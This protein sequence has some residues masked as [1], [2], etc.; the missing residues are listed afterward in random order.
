MS[1][2]AG[3]S[4]DPRRRLAAALR[5]VIDVSV[6]RP[7]EDDDL[8]AAAEAAEALGDRL[9]AQAGEGRRTR[10]VPGREATVADFLP[11]SPVIGWAN[12]IAPPVEVWSHTTDDGR[13]EL[14]GKVRFGHG[15]EGPPGTVHGGILALVFDEMLGAANSMARIRCMTGTL[16]VRY[17]KPTPLLADL[18][19]EA[20]TVEVNGRKV[21]T[22]GGIYHQGTLMAECDGLFIT[23]DV[24]RFLAAEAARAAEPG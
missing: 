15:Y 13:K 24:E 6:G 3:V 12:P 9:E 2:E 19:L 14:R 1:G 7:F 10:L 23:V 20:R 5:R 17:R 4:E 8:V 18:D 11:T 21:S 22:W 16:T